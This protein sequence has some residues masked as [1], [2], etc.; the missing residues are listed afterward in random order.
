MLLSLDAAFKVVPTVFKWDDSGF[1]FLFDQ[2][3]HVPLNYFWTNLALWLEAFLSLKVPI[4]ENWAAQI[5]SIN[6][7]YR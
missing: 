1:F 2:G 5:D 6:T 3:I 4:P 7:T